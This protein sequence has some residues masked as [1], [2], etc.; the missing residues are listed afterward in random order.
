MYIDEIDRELVVQ[1]GKAKK[2]ETSAN[3]AN[4]HLA[5]IRSVLRIAHDEWDCLDRIPKLNM[6]PEPTNRVRWITRGEAA[7][8]RT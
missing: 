3:T 2:E 8:R 1:I 4:H 7:R 5:L 6:Y